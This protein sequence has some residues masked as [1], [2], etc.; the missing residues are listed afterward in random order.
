MKVYEKLNVTYSQGR[1]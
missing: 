1:I